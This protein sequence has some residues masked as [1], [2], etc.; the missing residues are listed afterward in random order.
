MKLLLID[1]SHVYW[2]RWH[3]TSG[4][5]PDAAFQASYECVQSLRD[6]HD[7]TIVCCDIGKTWRH[8]L[9]PTYK[10]NRP[11]RDP[12]AYDQLRRLTAQLQRDGYPVVAVEG[13]EADDV[14]ATLAKQAP[15]SGYDVTIATGDK[16]LLQLVGPTVTV[17]STNAGAGSREPRGPDFVQQK[18]GVSPEQLRDWLALVGDKSD[19][20]KGCPGVGEKTATKLLS[21]FGTID[22]IYKRIE[23]IDS[24]PLRQKLTEHRA[25][26]ERAVELVTLSTGVPIT[27][28]DALVV[29]TPE[30]AATNE[31]CPDDSGITDEIADGPIEPV[32][33]SED[34]SNPRPVKLALSGGTVSPSGDVGIRPDS[35]PLA[36]TTS[37]A[38]SEAL[39]LDKQD[40]RW[41]LALEPRG[42]KQVWWLAE[43]FHESQ[44]YRKV[45]QN[46][47]AIAVAILK[48]R[49]LGLDMM[50]SLSV[51][52]V[53]E[54]M[55]TVAALAI[56]GIVIASGKAE[57]FEFVEGDERSATWATK[58]VGSRA[59]EI[60]HTYTIEEA[61]NAGLTKP[62]RSGFPS[63]WIR[64]PRPMLRKQ[65]GVELARLVYPDVGIVNLYDPDE[66]V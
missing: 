10:A 4:Q 52:R 18:F 14:I 43:H 56:V 50:T 64:L 32:G 15:A 62:S 36:S 46:S 57:Y 59:K 58:R 7:A 39:V 38:A 34:A 44:L 3:A 22:G 30:K 45:F 25:D 51:I 1:L 49:S 17:V 20:I 26:V 24:A 53:V 19:N 2:T 16:D 41:S 31:E 27:L 37:G 35:A 23:E 48:G 40:P 66:M 28:G 61:E 63:N 54:G 11:E 33:T 29:K 42:L 9:D 6:G 47:D 55:P 60:R 13:Y 12:A 65:A 21:D 8:A 5:G